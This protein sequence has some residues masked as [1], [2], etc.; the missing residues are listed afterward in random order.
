[1]CVSEIRQAFL[2][3]ENRQ[4]NKQRHRERKKHRGKYAR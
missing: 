1:M 2:E 3:H 4:G